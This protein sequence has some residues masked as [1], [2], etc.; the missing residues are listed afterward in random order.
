M[1]FAA[2]C[3]SDET[4]YL[5]YAK[6]AGKPTIGLRL[7]YKEGKVNGGEF[8]ILSPR[9][10]DNEDGV[11]YPLLDVI[12]DGQTIS[13]RTMLKNNGKLIEYRWTATVLSRNE[14]L[15]DLVLTDAGV[16]DATPTRFRLFK[17]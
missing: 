4:D 2:S 1:M 3:A 7:E 11:N 9:F 15:I 13:F 12:D 10:S 16:K 6:S 8:S 17:D 5:G 14:Q